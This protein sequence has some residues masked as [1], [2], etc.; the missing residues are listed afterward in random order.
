MALSKTSI[1]GIGVTLSVAV[2]A[3][4]GFFVAKPLYDSTTET[5]VS[6]EE[7][8]IVTMSK[9]GKLAQLEKG[10]DNIEETQKFVDD[11]LVSA[12]S[13]KDVESVSRAISTA[14]ISGVKISSFNFGAGENIEAAEVP[15]AALGEYVAPM[16]LGDGTEAPAAAPAEGEEGAATGEKKEALDTFQ[17]VPVQITVNADS[18][19][20]LSEY[21][22]ELAD[23]KRL[24]N[25][26]SV[27]STKGGG[28]TGMTGE[29]GSAGSVEATI[30]AYSFIYAR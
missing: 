1:Q 25:V 2:L 24:V 26:I 7:Q 22:D 4:T 21:V 8:K 6:L 14:L 18:Y 29:A 19:K 23:Q 17:R 27:T 13:N 20:K 15:K 10:V 12:P 9:T 5:K 28:G 30:Y 11:F 16:E 3:A